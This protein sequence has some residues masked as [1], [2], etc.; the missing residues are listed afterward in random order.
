METEPPDKLYN[1]AELLSSTLK[2]EAICSSETSIEARRTT[3]HPIPEDDT[4]HNHR[5]ENLKSY[6]T[7]VTCVPPALTLKCLHFAHV[8]VFICFV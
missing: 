6:C 3:R 4:L 2:M 1:A 5:C 8:T 7:M